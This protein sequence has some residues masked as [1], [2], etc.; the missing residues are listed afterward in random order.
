MP[1]ERRAQDRV[2]ASFVLRILPGESRVQVR[3]GDVSP[4]GL[5]VEL[6]HEVGAPGELRRLRLGTR[7]GVRIV[8]LDA[9]VIRVVRSDDLLAGP[10]IHGVAF[11]F[12]LADAEVR[13]RVDTFVEHLRRGEVVPLHDD[14][15][16]RVRAA[17]STSASPTPASATSD[18]VV[19]NEVRDSVPDGLCVR[20]ET[21]WKL[22][23]GERIRV[24]IPTETGQRVH[25]DAR[26]VESRVRKNGRFA[27][28][29]SLERGEDEVG[30]RDVSG[31]RLALAQR[32][33]EL[34][35]DLG[36]LSLPTVLVLLS[37]EQLS[38]VLR[39]SAEED[40]RVY[41]RHGHVVDVEG[42]GT[43]PR[44]VLARALEWSTGTFSFARRDVNREDRVRASTTAL[45]LDLARE[46]DENR[47]EVA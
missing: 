20:L 17:C 33:P 23:P 16:P 40:V 34:T 24:E 2:R 46:Q 37:M 43:S 39:L 3:A 18:A 27:T 35:G 5:F 11:E 7:D 47:R 25:V 14:A 9:R 12:V 45:L 44:A 26:A 6:D 29:F 15:S 32:T 4:T 30:E 31:I 1:Q 28:R 13:R 21:P 38:G 36:S 10:R 41:L 42:A 22:R 8:E 19:P